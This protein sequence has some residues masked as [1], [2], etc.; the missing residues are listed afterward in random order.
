MMIMIMMMMIMMMMMM[1]MGIFTA[2]AVSYDG[3]MYRCWRSLTYLIITDGSYTQQAKP[4]Q[5]PPQSHKLSIA[6]SISVCVC[7]CVCE[8][9]P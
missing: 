5:N 8:C 1:M 6:P 7:V 2:R 4:T 3:A 9:H